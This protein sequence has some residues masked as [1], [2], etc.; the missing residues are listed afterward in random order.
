MP[1]KPLIRAAQPSDVD[2][3]VRLC[4]EH[5]AYEQAQ[6]S[7]EGKA[8]SLRSAAFASVPRLWCFVAEADNSIVAYATCTRDFSTW[9]AADYLH[10]DCLFIDPR[11]RNAG[12]GTEMMGG[13]AQRAGALGC[14][15]L[16]WQTPAWNASAARFYARL[17]ACASTKL[18]FCWTPSRT[19]F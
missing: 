9:R 13:I 11:Y 6:F 2:D 4:A 1:T 12:V 8:E 19:D 3:V 10:M 15:T 14:A 16:E 18:R 5:A 17:G 7:P